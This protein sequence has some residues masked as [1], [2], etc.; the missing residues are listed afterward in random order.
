MEKV[1]DTQSGSFYVGHG[2]P[3]RISLLIKDETEHIRRDR[4]LELE[5]TEARMLAYALLMAAER[6][7]GT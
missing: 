4:E 6:E 1:L 3:G 2:L 7:Q 5:P